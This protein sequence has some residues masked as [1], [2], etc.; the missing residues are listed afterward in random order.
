[1][2]R[3]REPE[4]ARIESVTH[5]GRGIAAVAGKKVF[6]AG[7]LEGEEV[8][9]QR[10]K[11]RRNFDEA[12]LPEVLEASPRR[13][14]AACPVFGICGGCSLQHISTVEQRNIKLRALQDSFLRVGGVTPE[15][16]L[17]PIFDEPHG[18]WQYRRR[19]RLAVKDVHGKG[20]VLVGFRERHAPFVTD[21]HACD[22]LASPAHASSTR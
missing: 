18:D 11:R 15:T 14:T 13:I 7:A 20:R 16:W 4:I 19:A 5:D 2:A 8:R 10:R 9:F 3:R 1:M 22:V 6:V 21:M 12:E 17:E